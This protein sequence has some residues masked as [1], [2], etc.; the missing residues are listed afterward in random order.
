VTPAL[1]NYV[2]DLV[3]TSREHGP[4]LSPRAS[5]GLLRAAK[6]WALL[7]GAASVTPD[8]V[9]AVFSA[10]AEHRLDGGHRRSVPISNSLLERVDAIR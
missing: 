3:H 8:H 7:E 10:V 5:Q 6:A 2:L 1:I 4:G 9:Q